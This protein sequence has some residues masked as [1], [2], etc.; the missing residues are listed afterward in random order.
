MNVPEWTRDEHSINDAKIYLR[1]GATVDFF[2][3]IARNIIQNHPENLPLYAL[4]LVNNIIE[5]KEEAGDIELKPK[6]LEDNRYMRDMNVSEFLDAWVLALLCERPTSDAE[7]LTFHKRY[8]QSLIP[9][10]ATDAGQQE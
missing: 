2:E 5:G 4:S 9:N 1:Q 7:R 3:M 6:K 10:G 8:L